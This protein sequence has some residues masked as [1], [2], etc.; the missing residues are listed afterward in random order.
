M[1]WWGFLGERA[2]FQRRSVGGQGEAVGVALPLHQG[3]TRTGRDTGADGGGNIG[4]VTQDQLGIGS[5][6]GRMT[7]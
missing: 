5:H 7:G 3:Q 6:R 2:R 1:S 4:V